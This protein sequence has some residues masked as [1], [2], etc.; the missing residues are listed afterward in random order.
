MFRNSLR[1]EL[2]WWLLFQAC[3]DV[4]GTRTQAVFDEVF[5]KM[6]ADA[7]PIPGFRRVK[8]GKTY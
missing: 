3:V 7:Q 5:S 4:F 2:Y 8:G 6:V 1:T